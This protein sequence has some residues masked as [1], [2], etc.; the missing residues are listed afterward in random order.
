MNSS[1]FQAISQEVRNHHRLFIWAGALVVVFVLGVKIVNH[2]ARVAD[3]NAAI[4]Q[5]KVQSDQASQKA[6]DDQAKRDLAQYSAWKEASDK[7]VDGLYSAIASLAGELKQRQKQDQALPV[8]ALATRWQQQIEAGPE[9]VIRP[10]AGIPDALFVSS[11]AARK[12]VVLL[13]EIPAD[14]QQINSQQQIIAEKDADILKQ[15]SLMQDGAA[16]LAACR[17]TQ[18][19][20]ADACKKQITKIKADARRS[21]I[22]VFFIGAVTAVAAVFGL[23]HKL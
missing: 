5:K 22:K 23:G 10:D 7:R 20:A 18:K 8:P 9:D 15:K 14:R 21:K 12:T 6:A 13:D 3:I 1:N 11:S 4:A 16:Q 17:V 19:D 2:L